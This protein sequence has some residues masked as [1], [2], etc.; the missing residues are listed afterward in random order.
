MPENLRLFL[1]DPDGKDSYPIVTY[2]GL[3]LSKPYDDAPK[4]DALKR[5]VQWC[6]TAGQAF[7]EFLGYL[8]LAPHVVALSMEAVE[9]L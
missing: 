4:R 8:R 5:D 2:S 9:R 6:L 3:L 7:N 1:P